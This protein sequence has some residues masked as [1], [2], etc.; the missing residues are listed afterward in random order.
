MLEKKHGIPV[1]SRLFSSYD[2]S[3]KDVLFVLKTKSLL[4]IAYIV[5]VVAHPRPASC[6][7]FIQPQKTATDGKSFLPAVFG[8]TGS[9]RSWALAA[10]CL[11][12]LGEDGLSFSW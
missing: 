4:Q 1:T 5:V 10:L 11:S 3:L 7:I 12:K 2:E 9:W 8:G 6:P